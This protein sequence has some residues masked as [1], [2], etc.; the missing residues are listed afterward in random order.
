[1]NTTVPSARMAWPMAA[2]LVFASLFAVFR[3]S[4][5]YQVSDS[6]YSM[7]LGEDVIRYGTLRMDRHFHPPLNPDLYPGYDPASGKP[8]SIERVGD[9]YYYLFPPA[10]SILSSPF[11]GLMNL[12]G[13]SASN[14]DGTYSI[15][16]EVRLQR[17]LAAFLTALTGVLFLG[18]ASELLP[19]H[20]AALSALLA[21]LGSQ[22][23]S[24][25]SRGMWTHTWSIFLTSLLVWHLL[26]AESGRASF[27][28]LATAT[29]LSWMFFIRPPN[30]LFVIGVCVYALLARRGQFLPLAATGAGWF[31]LFLLHSRAVY[32]HWLP[33]YI[34]DQASRNM[35]L[36]ARYWSGIAGLLFSPSRGLLVYAPA[37]ALVVPLAV[38]RRGR[39]PVP[40]LAWLGLACGFSPVLVFAGYVEWY[41][42]HCFGARY[43]TDSLPWFFLVTVLVLAGMRAPTPAPR[44][45]PYL[46]AGL[47]LLAFAGVFTNGAGALSWETSRWNAQP[48][49]IQFEPERL[50]DLR[51][52]QFLAG[53]VSAPP[54]HE[55]LPAI[56]IPQGATPL[57][58]VD[59]RTRDA[60][61][62]LEG[63]WPDPSPDYRWSVSHRAAVNIRL[64]EAGPTVIRIT[65]GFFRNP[66][67][68]DRE[69]VSISIND[70]GL[71]VFTLRD[72]SMVQYAVAVPAGWW[73]GD[74]IIRFDLPDANAPDKKDAR[75]LGLSLQKVEIFADRRAENPP[76]A[77][78]PS[79]EARKFAGGRVD[80][81]AADA[82]AW[83]T[84]V[85][86]QPDPQSRWT[87]A[88]R[89]VIRLHRQDAA[90]G[91]LR[92]VAGAYLVPGRLERQRVLIDINGVK[93]PEQEIRTA[94]IA[95]YLF[96]VPARTWTGDC[97]IAIEL[98]DARSP[99]EL[100][101]GEDPRLLGLALQSIEASDAVRH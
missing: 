45:R 89:V 1:M 6:H 54:P 43:M 19:L 80:A 42:G 59:L 97:E 85:W 23:W 36:N 92:L 57:A 13:I 4:P 2:L 73:R 8:R 95:D 30:S 38:V 52:P 32:G 81:T 47:T 20:A 88:R 82:P 77:A 63:F 98:P 9:H 41:A 67:V 99:K 71:V 84:G 16:G 35:H 101:Q 39:L 31:A 65:T 68:S 49:N 96:P 44:G 29:L 46:A 10:S 93:L 60:G 100:G 48:D 53:L 78:S 40:R 90:E 17:N 87:V 26:R 18:I 50:W 28:P 75:L 5:V 72:Q 83:M 25:A 94:G 3:A 14:P 86:P 24:V 37:L 69:R 70:H 7:L 76:P 58:S 62:Q 66:G 12:A 56:P 21:G 34:R 61:N 33:L 91:T 74:N 55:V 51:R 11:I 64:D 79:A 27:N 22:A 15:A